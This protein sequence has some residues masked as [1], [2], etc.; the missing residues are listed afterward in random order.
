MYHFLLALL[1]LTRRCLAQTF[2]Q[3]VELD[4]VFPRANETYKPIAYFPTVWA[5]Q[6]AAA[7]LPFA[8]GVHWT[9][10]ELNVEENGRL[11]SGVMFL[12]SNNL[13]HRKIN[14][15][16]WVEDPNISPFLIV[17]STKELKN[18]T[19]EWALAWDFNL[20]R[21]CSR[22]SEFDKEPSW[23]TP[24]QH[25]KFN[26]STEG[27]LPDIANDARTCPSNPTTFEIRDT[28]KGRDGLDCPIFH[29][30]DEDPPPAD[31]CAFK[32]DGAV[33]SSVTAD[34]MYTAGCRRAGA[35]QTQTAVWPHIT[36]SCPYNPNSA[37]KL[38]RRNTLLMAVVAAV[39]GAVGGWI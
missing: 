34:M 21:N 25:V 30:E 28:M 10:T 36:T 29:R 1:F 37:A 24:T 8:I 27:K 12:T 7:I 14:A 32:I 13:T 3:T 23:T 15:D 17:D 38:D 39:L 11:F 9:L 2:P 6:N 35:T 18:A 5:V 16:R 26:I 33:A 31:P 19:G 22:H 4:L 20:L